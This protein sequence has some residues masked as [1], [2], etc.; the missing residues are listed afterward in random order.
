M[1]L[2]NKEVQNDQACENQSR[3]FEKITD[4]VVFPLSQL[5]TSM[6]EK[7][8]TDVEVKGLSSTIYRNSILQSQLKI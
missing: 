1:Y 2:Y 6:E 8:S 4:F 5:F 7:F 3:G